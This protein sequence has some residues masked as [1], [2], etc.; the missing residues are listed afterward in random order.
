M[1]ALRALHKILDG[2]GLLGLKIIRMHL[3]VKKRF[4]LHHYDGQGR[5]RV[6]FVRD[7]LMS[8]L[9]CERGIIND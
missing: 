7:L 2:T 5:S 4:R 1:D 3:L 6:R 8:A 9:R